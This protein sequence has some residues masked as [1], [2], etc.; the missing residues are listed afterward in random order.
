MWAKVVLYCKIEVDETGRGRRGWSG[1][2][3]TGG[4]EDGGERG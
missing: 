3:M 4:E 1:E 2:R